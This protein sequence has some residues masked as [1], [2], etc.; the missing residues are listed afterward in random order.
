[1]ESDIAKNAAYR[2]IDPFNDKAHGSIL[3]AD[4]ICF[5]AKEVDLI[6]PFNKELLR[7]AA[8]DLCV[9][10]RYFVNETESAVGDGPIRIPPNGLIY[11]ETKERFNLPYYLIARY[12]LRVH[13]VY[14]GLLIDNGL[15]VDP[16][17]IGHLWIPVHNMT[18]QDRILKA[19][20]EFI[21]VEFNRTTTLPMDVLHAT[22]EDKF[23]RQALRGEV[24]GI[25]G[26]P[27]KFFYRD[28]KQYQNRTK[29]F[30]PRKF[31]EKYGDETHK[32]ASLDTD[33]K[34]AK[35]QSQVEDQLRKLEQYGLIS[36]VGVLL[37]MLA[38]ILPIIYSQLTECEK[39]M[40]LATVELRLLRA[41]VDG[42]QKRIDSIIKSA[43]TETK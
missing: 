2:W 36:V 31:W 10:S 12:S 33:H 4:H 15:H 20:E 13:H 28:W 5:L 7:A 24:L 8:Y 22:S 32:S 11:I 37:A 14:R 41:R 21:S 1:M 25:G 16:G 27:A 6:V 38:I 40:T 18:A 35:V 17:Y 9:G 29:S 43:A 26:H 42:Q 39:A 3:L 23:I 34:L 30:T 19:G